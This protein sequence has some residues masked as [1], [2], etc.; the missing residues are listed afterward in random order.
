MAV[1]VSLEKCN[2][3][4]TC[5]ESCPA[6]ALSMGEEKVQI[7]ADECIDCGVCTDECPASALAL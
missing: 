5:V 4:G 1:K 6:G 3:C 2:G 7:S